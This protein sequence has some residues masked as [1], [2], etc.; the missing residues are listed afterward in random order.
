LELDDLA[1]HA[2]SAPRTYELEK[3][4]RVGPFRWTW[5]DLHGDETPVVIC[6]IAAKALPS[7]DQ[8]PGSGRGR[9]VSTYLLDF[10]SA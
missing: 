8:L 1:E 5:Q 7:S 9:P 2:L 6:R 3:A 10:A 4:E